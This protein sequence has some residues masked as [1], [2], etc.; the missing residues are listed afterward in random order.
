MPLA[1]KALFFTRNKSLADVVNLFSAQSSR[2]R[3]LD[4]RD[5][6]GFGHRVRHNKTD[7]EQASMGLQDRDYM[8]ER[9]RERSPFT[10]PP[11][12]RGGLFVVAVVLA[13]MAGLY[14]G[15]DWL[16]ARQAA[17][18]LLPTWGVG[19]PTPLP[20]TK[21]DEPPPGWQR[22]VVNGQT[23][24]S[25]TVCPSMDTDNAGSER[26]TAP[27]ERR[28]PQATSGSITLYHCKAYSGGTFWAN[29]HCNQHQALIDRLVE[30][31]AR[32]AF[33]Q[34]VEMAE[35]ERRS[36]AA[37]QSPP[38]AVFQ[39]P[40]ASNRGACDA[41]AQQIRHW[42]ALARQPQSAQTQDWIRVERHKTRDRQW[43][44]GC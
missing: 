22:C 14:L 27:V 6:G 44:L 28:A 33:S 5:N 35:G 42:D 3:Y 41:L 1:T 13:L 9:R 16:I 2:S 21:N 19:S 32:L 8:H 15:F 39:A 37:L 7:R 26:R 20:Q 34:Q 31:P 24:F 43:S 12:K 38:P 17:G 10:P 23:V 18:G 25:P 4:V 29:T 40:V 36:A 30:V 11:A